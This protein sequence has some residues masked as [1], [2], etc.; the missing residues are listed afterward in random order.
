MYLERKPEIFV[1]LR[2]FLHLPVWKHELHRRE[3]V[4]SEAIFIGLPGISYEAKVVLSLMGWR[5][6][7]AETTTDLHQE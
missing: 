4:N 6:V 3:C 7:K 5:L 2:H 1:L